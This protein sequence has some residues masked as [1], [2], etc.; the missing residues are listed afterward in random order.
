MENDVGDVLGLSLAGS[1][2]SKLCYGCL[3]DEDSSHYWQRGL[4]SGA[5]VRGPVWNPVLSN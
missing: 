3:V 5:A 4:G 2:T 1:Y